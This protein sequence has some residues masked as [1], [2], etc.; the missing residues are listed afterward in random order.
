MAKEGLE[1]KLSALLKEKYVNLNLKGKNKK[2]ILAELVAGI[3]ESGKLK[4]KA[5]FLREIA[6]RERLGSTGIGN[7]VAIPHAKSGQVRELMLG[8]GRHNEGI[9]FGALDG[10]KTHIFFI[11]ASP[12]AEVGSHLKI[13]SEISHLVKDKFIVE[14]L[15]KAPDKKDIL[16][17]IATY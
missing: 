2:S 8:F 5:A 13:L 3:A 17:I 7:S 15:K 12:K 4:N 10:A 1:I 6:K 9:D 14:R 11:L 16:R